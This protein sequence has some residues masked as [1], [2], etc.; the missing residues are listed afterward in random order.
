MREFVLMS[1]ALSATVAAV[2]ERRGPPP[3]VPLEGGFDSFVG[4]EGTPWWASAVA[5][6]LATLQAP[7]T[8]ENQTNHRPGG[9]HEN[10][11]NHRP[12]GTHEN[13]LGLVG[14]QPPTSREG[15]TAEQLPHPSRGGGPQE[16][17]GAHD[18]RGPH[19]EQV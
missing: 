16:P 13:R 11:T 2:E 3:E 5:V 19:Q 8:H 10:Q 6:E 18:N 12:G 9:T 17:A 15:P 7:A 1:A 14:Q 4:E